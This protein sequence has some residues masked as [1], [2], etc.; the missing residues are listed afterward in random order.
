MP[1][2]VRVFFAYPDSPSNVGETIKA[3]IGRLDEQGVLKDNNV[4]IK[5]WSQTSVSG[6]RLDTT[7]LRQIDRHDVFACDLTYPNLNVSFE[8]G[9]AIAKFKRVMAC[10]NPG[11]MNAQV[12]YSRIYKNLLN[13][14]YLEYHN[15]ECLGTAIREASPWTSLDSTYLHNRFRNQQTRLE[16]PTLVYVKPPLHSDSVLY[17]HQ[18]LEASEFGG[19]LIVDDPSEFSTHNLEWYADR[20]LTAD[21]IVIH[22]LSSEHVNNQ[23]HNL[24]ASLIAGLAIGFRKPM[25]MLAHAPY[26]A[27]AD[28]GDW[29]KIHD[30]ANNCVSEV[31]SWL[32]QESDRLPH[33][34]PRRE[35]GPLRISEK[36]DIR[37]LFLGDVVA[38]LE[39]DELH[40]YFVETASYHR[41][42][43]SPATILLGRRGTGKTAILFAIVNQLSKI[44]ENHITVLK[45]VGYETHG[46]I[47]VLNDIRERSE[48]GFLIESLWKFLIYSEIAS[49]LKHEIEDRPAHLDRSKDEKAF[50]EY[51]ESQSTILSPPFSERLGQ[52]LSSLEGIG[53]F[54]DAGAQRRR[55]SEELHN[56]VIGRLRYYLGTVLSE[57]RDL[58]VLIDGL[59][60]PWVPGEHIA[61]LAE[62][63]GG[64]L[65]VVQLLPKE[66]GKSSSSLKA[67]NAK[68]IVL[69]RSDIFAFLKHRLPE[70]DKL[71]I[72]RVFWS[73]RH[74]LIRVLEERLLYG[75]PHHVKARDIWTALFPDS[76][77]GLSCTEYILQS[78]L[79]R[80]R[81]V[82]NLLKRAVNVSVN[83]GHDTVLADDLLSARTQ[84]S[85][86]AF[87]S[88]VN[89]DDPSKGKLEEV[90]YEFAGPSSI[91]TKHE[92]ELRIESAGVKSEDVEHYLDLLCDISF[93]G[94]ETVDGFRFAQHEEDRHRLRN[95]ARVIA[96]RDDRSENYKV[97][98]AFYP[99]LGI[100]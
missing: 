4:R 9:Y 83:R 31:N 20:F 16:L 85:Y 98:P 79:P 78:V 56:H 60:G 42:I 69:L 33:R 1:K 57:K 34:R 81:D 44:A 27:P 14:G 86:N 72:E 3:S 70:Q 43:D 19:S 37:S 46:L 29:L 38:E 22:L 51:Y 67:V 24:K 5:P 49:S 11:I 84:Y 8:L 30:T 68:V 66:L 45:P 41:A 48:R 32:I 52:A 73:D 13:M 59:D 47:R 15:H 36:L 76:V 40:E 71:P 92:I 93:L 21:A 96:S 61:P 25:I 80:P 6:K 82:I 88:I 77:D 17:T 97:N 58:T 55:I 54:T 12:R 65:E 18:A 64:L 91:C 99:V 87:D 26:Q 89:E 2:R 94:V 53:E 95:L 39:S 10:I 74:Q 50:L 90:L 100:E 75:A 28:Y 62:L 35:E 63:I 23:H 7:I